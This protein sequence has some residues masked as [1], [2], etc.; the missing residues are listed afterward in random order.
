MNNE[1]NDKEAWWQ[2]AIIMFAK[3]SSWIFFPIIIGVP[4]GRWLDKVYGT[5]PLLF[6]I[7]MGISFLISIFGLVMEVN[8]EYQKIEKE[9]KNN[10]NIKK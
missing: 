6:I 2:P 9:N 1:K 8:K 10:S 4:L 3:F 7:A 5:A